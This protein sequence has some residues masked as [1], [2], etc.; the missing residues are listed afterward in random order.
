M[1]IKHK[2]LG[3]NVPRDL[4][5]IFYCPLDRYHTTAVPGASHFYTISFVKAFNFSSSS[6]ILSSLNSNSFL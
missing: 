2:S 6:L 1:V 4:F 5:I 3:T